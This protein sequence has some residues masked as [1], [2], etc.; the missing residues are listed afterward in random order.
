MAKKKELNRQYQGGFSMLELVIVI[1]I[2]VSLAAFSYTKLAEMTESVERTDFVRTMNRI[3]AQLTLKIADWYA[4]GEIVSRNWVE[5][6]NPM[7]LIEVLPENYAGEF[8][9][10]DLKHC[11]VSK[12]CYL[13]DK[14]WLVYRVKYHAELS[15]R[16]E[17]KDLL[18]LKTIVTFTE[19]GGESG[20]ATALTLKPVYSFQWQN[21]NFD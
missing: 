20:L 1:V 7:Q 17:H 2:V 10:A 5:K 14:H 12:W 18:V 9:S 15:N 16:F 13:T 3:Q 6:S 21:E 4:S 8:S 11:T 19:N